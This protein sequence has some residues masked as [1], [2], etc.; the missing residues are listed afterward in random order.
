[1]KKIKAQ[2]LTGTE[3]TTLET[4]FYEVTSKVE[5]IPDRYNKVFIVDQP[6]I[7]GLE[8]TEADYLARFGP[9]KFVTVTI[10]KTI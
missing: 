10:S 5:S 3:E 7:G 4:T 9:G 8:I 2:A 6:G 1:M